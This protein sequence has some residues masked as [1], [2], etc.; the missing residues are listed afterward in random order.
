MPCFPPSLYLPIP[1]KI[2][3]S[4]QK[5]WCLLILHLLNI[6]PIPNVV[7]GTTRITGTSYRHI[8]QKLVKK[9]KKKH[10]CK[11]EF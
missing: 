6:Y 7:L 5:A 10:K 4:Y 2:L 1:S 3:H 9:K 11:F 8:F